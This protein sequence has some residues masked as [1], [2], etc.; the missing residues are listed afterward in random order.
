MYASHSRPPPAVCL[1]QAKS[2]SLLNPETV[3]VS[4]WDPPGLMTTDSDSVNVWLQ[5]TEK[6]TVN[7]Y[8]ST[9]E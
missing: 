2:W 5:Q 9:H 4:L 6:Q 1:I 3:Q 8:N 7:I